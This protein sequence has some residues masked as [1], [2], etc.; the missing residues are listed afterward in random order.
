MLSPIYIPLKY[1]MYPI[2]NTPAVNLLRDTPA[3]NEREETLGVLCLAC[4]DPRSILFTLWSETVQN[5]ER[6]YHFT[7]CDTEPA[8]L[9]RNVVLLT[10]IADYHSTTDDTTGHCIWNLFYHMLISKSDLTVLQE[11]AAKLLTASE[12]LQTWLTSSYGDYVQLT[13][14]ATLTELRQYW[15]QYKTMDVSGR[16]VANVREGMSQRSKEIAT[17]WVTGVAGGDCKSL[18]KKGHANP[19]FAVSSAPSGEFAVHYGT[20]PLLGF[21]LAEAFRKLHCGEKMTLAAQGDR[22]VE[23]AKTQFTAWCQTFKKFVEHRRVCV[24]LFCGDALALCHQLQ[25]RVASTKQTNA[26]RFYTKPWKLQPLRLDGQDGCNDSRWPSMSRFDVVDTSN[27]GDHVGLINMI[28]A[29]APLL[30]NH[31]TSILCTESL[32]AASEDPKTSLSNALESDVAT[33]SLLIG[34]APIGLL[35]GTTLEAVSNE[36]ELA[37]L[38]PSSQRQKQ[39]QYRLRIHWKSPDVQPFSAPRDSESEGK[40]VKREKV[41]ASELAAWLFSMY[42]KMFAKEDVSTLFSTAQRMQS[43]HFST[44]LQR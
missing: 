30:R 22:L 24:Q 40:A 7:C 13:N 15:S 21:H 38:T 11:H 17:Y 20:E 10:M 1:W 3:S 37:S 43:N 34:L 6:R 44:D 2:G 26:A 42:K 9:A 8:I 28:V 29:E 32:L 23:A 12:S 35:A 33:F 36:A 41:D 31:P 14:E 25:L 19:M 18:G 39:S 5:K 4:G 27:L 16:V